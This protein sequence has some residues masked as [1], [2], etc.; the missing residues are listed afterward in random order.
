MSSRKNSQSSQSSRSSKYSENTQLAKM[1]Q[2]ANRLVEQ[3]KKEQ[4]EKET[5]LREKE[6]R[7]IRYIPEHFPK[8]SRDKMK[9]MNE[10]NRKHR[11]K[12]YKSEIQ[13]VLKS[14]G[15][16]NRALK[17]S[18]GSSSGFKPIPNKAL[19]DLKNVTEKYYSEVKP[20]RRFPRK[21]GGSRHTRKNKRNGH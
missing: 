2:E 5:E 13:K 7:L 1:K 12:N 19:F 6:D 15:L 20:S 18:S 4:Q 17:D 3:L 21:K 9:R 10:M 8:E 11:E 14:Q 16:I